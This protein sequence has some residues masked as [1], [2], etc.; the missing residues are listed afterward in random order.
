[1]YVGLYNLEPFVVNSAMMRVSSHH[2]HLGD[3]VEI[4]NPLIKEQY[5]LIYLFS[6]FDFTPK[7][8]IYSNMICGGSGFNL[9]TTL[10]TTI[11]NAEYDWTLYPD[12]T[13][14]I[15]WFS[16]GCIRKCSFCIVPLKEGKIKAVQP[17]NLN[18]KG[19]YIKIMDNNFFANPSWKDARKYLLS[20]HQPVDF[21]GIDIRLPFSE[22]QIQLLK[23]LKHK[24]QIKIAWDNPEE[25]IIPNL[26][27]LIKKIP[28]YKFLC[29]VLIVLCLIDNTKIRNYNQY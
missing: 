14:S 22:Q 1:M 24:K 7:P 18:P 3:K 27:T 5:D 26:T 13:Y 29:Y 10:P 4:Y 9:T 17:K 15:L 16:T 28:A 12:C 8:K 6:I 19:S 20:L 21:Q 2:K 23:S 25:D 11:E